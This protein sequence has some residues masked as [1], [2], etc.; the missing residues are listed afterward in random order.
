VVDVDA[1]EAELV[2][3]PP[4]L[5]D[6]FWPDGQRLAVGV[7]ADVWPARERITGRRVAIK[8]WHRPLSG[9]RQHDLYRREVDAHRLVAQ[10]SG[11]VVAWAGGQPEDRLPWIA[12]ALHGTSLREVLDIEGHPPAPEAAVLAM[13]LL[14]GLA[15]IHGSGLLHRDIKPS[16]VFVRDGR[17]VLGDLGLSM[18]AGDT[19]LD[20]RAGTPCY[21]APELLLDGVPNQ[22]TDVYSA[23]LVLREL[24]GEP[25]PHLALERVIRQAESTL[26][27][28]RPSS[29]IDLA[30]SFADACARAGLETLPA[31]PPEYTPAWLLGDLHRRRFTLSRLPEDAVTAF[32]GYVALATVVGT[33]TILS[34]V[35]LL[36]A[37]L[38]SAFSSY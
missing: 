22:R 18:L 9:R 19:V 28:D 16:N 13:D 17:A 7:L 33:I 23:A 14:H 38:F 36:L 3:R 26:P 37:G 5:P 25:A 4:W 12:T 20:P 29:G 31:R 30:S 6:G 21:R 8:L 27:L 32:L 2:V 15:A 10:S 11:H 24:L 34:L 1:R 35:L